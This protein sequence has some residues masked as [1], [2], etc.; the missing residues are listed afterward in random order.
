MQADVDQNEADAD[1][2]IAAVQADVDANEAAAPK[3]ATAN[4]MTG[5]NTFRDTIF[6]NE[7]DGEF[8]VQ[9]QRDS[10]TQVSLIGNNIPSGARLNINTTNANQDDALVVYSSK[11]WCRA[12]GGAS[13]DAEFDGDVAVDGTLSLGGDAVTSTAAELNILDGVTATTTELNL[14]DGVTATTAE[15]NYVDGVT[16]NIQTQLDAKLSAETIT[17]TAFKAVVAAS[18]DFADFQTRVAAL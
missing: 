6:Y 1:A 15:L 18:S 3:L 14:L 9:L 5:Q 16:S 11:F 13:G 4:V 7:V 17:L 10:T 2:A 8:G 12:L